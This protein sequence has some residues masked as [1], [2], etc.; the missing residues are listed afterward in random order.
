MLWSS[1]KDRLNGLGVR[2]AYF[3]IVFV[4]VVAHVL[5]TVNS[6]IDVSLGGKVFT[7]AIGLPFSWKLFYFGALAFAAARLIYSSVCPRIIRDFD[8]YS[9]YAD[10]GK[11]S[12]FICDAYYSLATVW[13][14]KFLS[15]IK[16]DDYFL[17]YMIVFLRRFCEVSTSNEAAASHW[18][19]I[20]SGKP[21][22]ADQDDRLAKFLHKVTA[23]SL[24][25][26]YFTIKTESLA[27]AFWY[28]RNEADMSH[29]TFRSVC[30]ALYSIGAI[31]FFF[32]AAQGFWFVCRMLF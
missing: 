30:T 32:V 24:E 17:A 29:E 6:S 11:G 13:T 5:S 7:L 2:S 23:R 21:L 9:Q 4:P 27:D 19:E 31:L 26:E 8:T 20:T 22:T 10:V 1:L 25:R 28:T 3:W 16:D 14:V 12:S 15:G 18:I